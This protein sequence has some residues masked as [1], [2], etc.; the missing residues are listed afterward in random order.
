MDTPSRNNPSLLLIE[1]NHSVLGPLRDWLTMT[2][3]DLRLIET[4]DRTRGISLNRSQKPDVVLT[5]IS[6]LGRGGV[7]HIRR[8]KAA[9]PAAAV[10]VLVGL[11]S[12]SYERALVRAGAEACTCIWKL[13]TDLLPR[14]QTYLSA[15]TH[16]IRTT[17]CT[18]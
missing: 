5:D 3:P 8:V 6:A 4:T 18:A 17:I 13:R 1:E 10:F 16:R 2:F 9:Q 15:P 11:D 12:P 7:E 14:L